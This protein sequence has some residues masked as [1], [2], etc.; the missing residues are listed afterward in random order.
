MDPLTETEEAKNFIVALVSVGLTAEKAAD[1]YVATKQ[2]GHG[3][4][5]IYKLPL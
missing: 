2:N 3:K 1:V 5:I 4:W